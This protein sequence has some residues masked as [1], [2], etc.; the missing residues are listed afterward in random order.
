MSMEME[1][2]SWNTMQSFRL[3]NEMLL[4]KKTVR[5]ETS[6]KYAYRVHSS[7]RNGHEDSQDECN[8]ATQDIKPLYDEDPP[9]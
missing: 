9:L 5:M 3:I 6:L 8:D 4:L 2:E 7:V 1:G